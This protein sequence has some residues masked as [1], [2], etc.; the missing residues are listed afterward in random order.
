M[1]AP[2][3]QLFH[4]PGGGVKLVLTIK[5]GG[6]VFCDLHGRGECFSS[7]QPNFQDTPEHIK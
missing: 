3:E 7:C 1:I 4:I 5:G 6:E 2:N